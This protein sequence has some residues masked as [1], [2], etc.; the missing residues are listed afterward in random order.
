V[1]AN[2]STPRKILINISPIPEIPQE[3]DSK[4]RQSASVLTSKDYL[5]QKKGLKF[6]KKIGE[7]QG[8]LFVKRNRGIKSQNQ[9][10]N[11][12]KK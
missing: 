2:V 7:K 11:M 5:A 12:S 6:V 4:R 8:D 9:K 3:K 10:V 1:N